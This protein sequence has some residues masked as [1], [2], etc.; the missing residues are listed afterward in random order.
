VPTADLV[1]DADADSVP[2]CLDNCPAIA[3]PTQLDGDGDGAGDVCDACVGPGS[4]DPDGDGRC[5]GND[6]CPAVANPTQSDGDA[7]GFGDECDACIGP[8]QTDGDGDLFCDPVDNCPALAN[9]DQAD[10]D[11]DGDGDVCDNCPA[12]ANPTQADLDG[13]TVGDACDPDDDGDGLDDAAD[14]CQR[15][16]NPGQED[17]DGDG[18]GDLCDNC[19]TTAN[20]S[21]SDFDQDGLGDA[22]DPCTIDGVVTPPEQC[23]DGNHV[24]TDCCD[25][26][27]QA[28]PNGAPCPDDGFGCT[29]EACDNAGVCQHA[30]IAAGTVCRASAG[31]CDIVEMC[32][33]VNAACPAN[34]TILPG[35]TCRA[36]AGDCDP[37]EECSGDLSCPPDVRFGPLVECRSAQGDCDLAERCTGASPSCPPDLKRTG[38]CRAAS[39]VCDVAEVCNGLVTTC[40]ANAFVADGTTCD[41]GLFCNGVRQCAQGACASAP[42]PCPLAC[43]EGGDTCLTGC[44]AHARAGCRTAERSSLLLT[45]KSD[46]ARDKLIWK[47]TKGQATDLADFGDPRAS[48]DYVLCL[49]AGTTQALLTGGALAVPADATHWAPVRDKGFAFSDPSAPAGAQKVILKSSPTDRA[50]LIVK[51]KGTALGDPVIPIA[52]SELPLVVQLM[53]SET[54]VCWQS[55]FAVADNRPGKFK[56]KAP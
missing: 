20:P 17:G 5:T 19:P 34:A 33:G 37:S 48:A 38:T 22:C 43:D 8:G 16:V 21:Q 56:A 4:V 24:A 14:N 23:D 9:A 51:G 28:A 27:C 10:A 41:D 3:N 42:P 44:P 26:L 13:D 29:T 7:D 15:L 53:N 40:P 52:P 18:A 11:F 6:N 1:A 55:T 45:D 50:K 2:N 30:L 39:G 49:Y 31:D 36:S 54:P 47:W 46:D 35:T 12:I 32:D 25:N